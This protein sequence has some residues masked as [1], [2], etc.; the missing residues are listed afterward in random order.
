MVSIQAGSIG[1]KTRQEVEAGRQEQENTG[2][3]KV[4]SAVLALP[5]R[6]Q[7]VTASLNKVPSHV[8]SIDKNNGLIMGYRSYKS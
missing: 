8:A 7:D 2:K 1:G 3:R 4:W 5:Q 6:K